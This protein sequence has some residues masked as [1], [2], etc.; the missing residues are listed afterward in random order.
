M[1][2][3]LLNP[4]GGLVM[5]FLIQFFQKQMQ[6]A[7]RAIE[8]REAHP[9]QIT[10][11]EDT[12]PF[13]LLVT[14]VILGWGVV[15]TRDLEGALV[16]VKWVLICVFIAVTHTLGTMF[17][18]RLLWDRKHKSLR[19]PYYIQTKPKQMQDEF[20][21]PEKKKGRK[22]EVNL[23]LLFPEGAYRR[24]IPDDYAD[25]YDATLGKVSLLPTDGVPFYTDDPAVIR[26]RADLFRELYESRALADALRRFADSYP[27]S[28]S[29][30]SFRESLGDMKARQ[31]AVKTL[32]KDLG[33]LVPRS[34]AMKTLKRALSDRSGEIER[35]EAAFAEMPEDLFRVQSVTLAVNLDSGGFAHEAGI[36]ALHTEPFDDRDAMPLLRPDPERY[37]L[38][39]DFNRELMGCVDRMLEEAFRRLRIRLDD[40][41]GA[42]LPDALADEIRFA[43]GFT[44]FLKTLDGY[45]VRFGVPDD[46]VTLPDADLAA[47][48]RQRSLGYPAKWHA[49]ASG[50]TALALRPF[51]CRIIISEESRRSPL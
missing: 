44:D 35:A 30:R 48:F 14:A 34:D 8:Y 2:N 40:L 46:D 1:N 16:L 12:Y 25:A 43:A 37:D 29:D 51:G 24:P 50:V 15:K 4:F 33:P 26:Y 3:V 20:R 19:T 45:T 22:G 31:E 18:A 36:I 38:T 42:A 9:K 39:L 6:K 5:K 23:R 10:R 21:L 17:L 49:D 32:A 41:R 28:L 13:V 47:F 27:E 7:I 11:R